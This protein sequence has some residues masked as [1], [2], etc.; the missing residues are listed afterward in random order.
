MVGAGWWVGT[1]VVLGVAGLGPGAVSYAD[2]GG[3]VLDHPRGEAVSLSDR[4]DGQLAEFRRAAESAALGTPVTYGDGQCYGLILEYNRAL[5]YPWRL[6]DSSG[7][8]FDLYKH[9]DTNGL[10]AYYDRI[11]FDAGANL[12]QLGDIVIYDAGGFISQYGHA[13]VVTA[14]RGSGDAF[15]YQLAEQNSGGR[16]F[17]TENWR[18]FA[19]A[20]NTLGYLRPK[21]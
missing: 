17:V 13:G 5:G 14:V 16:L 4:I 10:A 12:P 15:G 19:P 6:R 9:F 3:V 1:L 2:P 18:D 11:P 7:N 20:W 8:A 21:V